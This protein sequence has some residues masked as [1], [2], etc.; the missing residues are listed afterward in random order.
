MPTTTS[1]AVLA[2]NQAFYRAFNERDIRAMEQ[3][4]AE[5]T[6]V[7]CAHPGWSPLFGRQAVMASWNAIFGSAEPPQIEMAEPHVVIVDH[8]AFV[9]CIEHLGDATICAT[10]IF[11]EEKGT[12]RLVHHHG[13]PMSSARPSRRPFSRQ[14]N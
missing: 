9:I 4:W 3:V 8:T 13:G 5:K 7:S 2:A 10:N 6:P 12:W 14:M 1:D 11:V